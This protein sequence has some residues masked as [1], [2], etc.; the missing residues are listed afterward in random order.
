MAYSGFTTPIAAAIVGDPK[1][2]HTRMERVRWE[3]TDLEQIRLSWWRGNRMMRSPVE[4]PEEDLFQLL[5]QAVNTGVL[6][7]RFLGELRRVRVRKPSPNRQVRLDND[8]RKI[9]R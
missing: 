4:L 7:R 9:L 5:R 2:D 6:S 3:G 8:E 1:D